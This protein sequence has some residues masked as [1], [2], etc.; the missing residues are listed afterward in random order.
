MTIYTREEKHNHK[1][2]QDGQIAKTENGFVI[3]FHRFTVCPYSIK[4]LS[5]MNR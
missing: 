5:S 2:K 1:N 3:A 4:E